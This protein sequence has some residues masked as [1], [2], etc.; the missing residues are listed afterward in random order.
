MEDTLQRYFIG[1]IYSL[2][3]IHTHALNDFLTNSL[4]AVSVPVH[5]V[6]SEC[7]QDIDINLSHIRRCH[8]S[9]RLHGLIYSITAYALQ[10]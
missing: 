8:L 9:N 3:E 5:D 2:E 1:T 6:V 10:L 4:D 7:P